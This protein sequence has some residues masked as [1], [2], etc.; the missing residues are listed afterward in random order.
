MIKYFSKDLR[1]ARLVLKHLEPNI[2]NAK[3]IFAALKNE[4]PQDYKYEPLMKT[5]K[6]LPKSV[7][8]LIIPGGDEVFPRPADGGAVGH[9]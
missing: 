1:S 5:P 4:N 6:I 7:G 8:A 9:S 3:I 2:Q